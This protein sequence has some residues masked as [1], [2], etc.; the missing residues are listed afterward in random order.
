MNKEVLPPA[1]TD[2]TAH[3]KPRTFKIQIDKTMYDVVE[4]RPTGRF[5]LELAG[6]TPVLQFAIY[7]KVKGGQPQ[8]IALDE[9]VDLAEPGV[10][11]FVTLPLDQTEG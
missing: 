11:R 4:Q 3:G 5:L 7:I 2:A 6:K 1:S 9:H 8:R 10:D